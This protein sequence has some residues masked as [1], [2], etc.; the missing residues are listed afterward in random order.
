MVSVDEVVAA[1]ESGA[2]EECFGTGTAAV[3]S[4]V[5]ELRFEEEHME[6]SGGRIEELTQKIYDT[7]T[8]IQLGKVS[9][10]KGWSVDVN[11]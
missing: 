10:P 5:G 3:I 1:A 8:G 4:P 6:I 11:L 9:G 2:M 7:I